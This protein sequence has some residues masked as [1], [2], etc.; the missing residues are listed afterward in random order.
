MKLEVGEQDQESNKRQKTMKAVLSEGK[1]NSSYLSTFG[2]VVAICH[3]R[4]PF[5][6]LR[7]EVRV[8]GILNNMQNIKFKP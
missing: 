5:I 3:A 6:Q 4:I 7:K 8:T 2:H 1:S